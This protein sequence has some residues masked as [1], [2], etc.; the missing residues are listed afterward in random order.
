MS[1]QTL[2]K[3]HLADLHALAAELGIERYRLLDR[4]G[5]VSAIAERDPDAG[6]R[7]APAE[8]KKQQEPE[9]DELLDPVDGVLDITPRGHGFIRREGLESG[10]DDVYVSPSQIR[11]CELVRGDVVAGPVRKPRRGERHPALVHIDTVNGSEPGGERRAFETLT[12]VPPHRRIPLGGEHAASAEESA[13]LRAIDL[14]APLARGQRVLVRAGRGAGRTTLMQALTAELNA[15]EDLDVVVVLID[16]RPEEEA[17][18]RERAGDA[19]LAIATADM[20]TRDQLR[21]VEL[22][23][24]GAKRRAEAGKDVV[25]LIDSLSR[26][27]ALADDPGRAKPI[28]GAGRETEESDAGSLTVIATTLRADDE[29]GVDRALLT[30][31]NATV[32]L[33]PELAADGI[34]PALEVGGCRTSGEEKLRSDEELAGARALRAELA[35]LPARDAAERLRERLKAAAGNETLLTSLASD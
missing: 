4:A 15:V 17:G 35:G 2:E 32:T 33:D 11:R 10:E 29:D 26:L 24:S 27:A 19:E 8:P 14:L 6:K 5:L 22:A 21:V 13:L 12:A 9:E 20:R 7:E 1:N 34:W 18:W 25:L 28:F 31:E 23:T 30:T 16:E 3:R